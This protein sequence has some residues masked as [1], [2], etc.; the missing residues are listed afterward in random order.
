MWIISVLP[1]LG[2]SICVVSNR[3]GSFETHPSSWEFDNEISGLSGNAQQILPDELLLPWPILFGS[4]EEDH[5][6]FS[7]TESSCCDFGDDRWI[8][9]WWDA[10]IFL[11]LFQSVGLTAFLQSGPLHFLKPLRSS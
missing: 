10:G 1:N 5:V 3:H 8:P 4:F 11:D 6:N 2:G 9:F 7:Q